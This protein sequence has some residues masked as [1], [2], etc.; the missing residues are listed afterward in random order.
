MIGKGGG[1]GR[2]SRQ[3]SLLVVLAF[4][5]SAVRG[6]SP[7]QIIQMT[8]DSERTADRN[9]H[10]NWI[11]LEQSDKPKEHVVQWVASTQ[12]SSVERALQG[13][14]QDIPE[15][16]RRAAIDKFLHDTK[17]QDKQISEADL[18]NKQIDDLLKLL[19]AAFV[20]TV[21]GTSPHHD[22][23][24]PRSRAGFPS[25]HSGRTCVQR[26]DRRSRSG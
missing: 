7:Q 4:S 8:V 5:V 2:K 15:S 1:M 9:D 20:W 17:A 10:P 21:T 11:Y 12:Q 26:H 24:A 19:L 16:Q 23:L 25:P 22:F 6:Q 3:F 18:D 14:A 13:D